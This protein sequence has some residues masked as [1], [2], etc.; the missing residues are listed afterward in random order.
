M[1]EKKE[2]SSS[3]T[4]ESE[5][6]ERTPNSD[7][8]HILESEDEFGTAEFIHRYSIDIISENQDKN[9]P[10]LILHWAVGRKSPGEWTKPEDSHIP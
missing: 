9:E 7:I 3:E 5:D 8:S 6:K 4:D 2:E 1:E 10:D